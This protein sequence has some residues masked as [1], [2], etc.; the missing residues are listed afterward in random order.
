MSCLR[1][2]KAQSD[3]LWEDLG[4]GGGGRLGTASPRQPEVQLS[5]KSI[6]LADGPFLPRWRFRTARKDIRGDRVLYG[7]A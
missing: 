4:G 3:L 5:T 7:E 6:H 2:V 1:S